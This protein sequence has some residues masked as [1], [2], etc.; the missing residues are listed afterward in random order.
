MS[1]VVDDGW[2]DDDDDLGLSFN[3][4]G[5][6]NGWGDDD[7]LDV[8]DND[9]D[10]GGNNDNNGWGDDDKDLEVA[11]AGDNPGDG[12]GDDD[13]LFSNDGSDDDDDLPSLDSI[14]SSPEKVADSTSMDDH[15]L[16]EKHD[17]S[18]RVVA[19][20]FQSRHDSIPPP[21]PPSHCA[22]TQINH[23][24]S[25]PQS[26][27]TVSEL[28]HYIGSLERILS[29][30]NAVLE[31]EYN[32]LQKAEELLEYYQSRPQLAEYTR[33]KE[34]KRM[35]YEVV[36]SH[37][38]V[39]TNK[40]RII[41]DNL[42]PDHAIVSRAANQSLL[43]DLLQVITGQD[44]IVRPQYLT[45]CV[46]TWCKFTIH[47]G[48]HGADML[49]C[50]AKLSLSLPT[51]DGDRLLIAEVAV[52]VLFSPGQPMVEF[53]VQ[54]IDVLLEDYSKLAGVAE[55]LNAMEDN[56]NE[57]TIT[58]L[59]NTNTSPDMYRDAFLEKSQ[60]LLSLSSE[61]MKSAFQQMDSVVN[62]KGKIKKISSFIP[63]TDQLL[64][65]EQEAMA[66]AEARKE[67]LQQRHSMASFPR[68][69][70]PPP[71][72]RPPDQPKNNVQLGDANR[73]KSI[74][75]GLVRSGWK[76]LAKS[77]VL[78]DEDPA[79]YGVPA[80]PPPPR[81]T[82][83]NKQPT[84]QQPTQLY[85]R[86][87]IAAPVAPKL[88]TRDD[89]CNAQNDAQFQ[90]QNQNQRNMSA[91]TTTRPQMQHQ[92]EGYPNEGY[93][94]GDLLNQANANANEN[95]ISS[96]DSAGSHLQSRSVAN[97][98]TQVTDILQ[99]NENEMENSKQAKELTDG[100]TDGLSVGEMNDLEVD[101]E[102]DEN[103][104]VD[105]WDDFGFDDDDID[106]TNAEDT[107]TFDLPKTKGEQDREEEM[108][109]PS[110]DDA[111]V[112]DSPP[113]MMTNTRAPSVD[114]KDNPKDYVVETRKRWVNPRPYRP[115]IK[116]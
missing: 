42:L 65:A 92:R 101:T 41:L 23:H 51:V 30:I 20:G 3:S 94:N 68:P 13:E 37:G 80:P 25:P 59:L 72:P 46:A 2:G 18:A 106:D 74:L 88:Y 47:Q 105:G 63:D 43:A 84:A 52:C 98:D 85:K 103:V 97:A 6:G 115:Y 45:I 1:S 9:A 58:E 7:D 62:I 91:M 89:A 104:D 15:C 86:E 55:F 76:T 5:G 87:E 33:T 8:S 75:G 81:V 40:E 21:P 32:T 61:G 102:V 109:A 35:N 50:R 54:K 44:L 10:A 12:W 73:P 83:Y 114:R 67:E 95:E 107:S 77:V 17:K 14:S 24:H 53:K 57:D 38:H 113:P 71:P 69:P 79:I 27:Q 82:L 19:A 56:N 90:T 108:F 22:P 60:R 96:R 112:D 29:S 48:D 16:E 4:E 99:C 93:P 39:E 111:I 31:F 64:E 110:S 116:G 26:S 34:L 100:F 78:P 49:D 11:S 70:P 36:L 28:S 66:F